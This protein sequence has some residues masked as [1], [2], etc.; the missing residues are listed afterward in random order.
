MAR[1]V[2]GQAPP[3]AE[4]RKARTVDGQAPLMGTRNCYREYKGN[5]YKTMM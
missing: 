4:R 1:G 5:E 3:M 2:D